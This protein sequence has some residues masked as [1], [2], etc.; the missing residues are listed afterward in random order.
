M[1]MPSI[2]IIKMYCK[3]LKSFILSNIKFNI[4]LLYQKDLKKCLKEFL[5]MVTSIVNY[6]LLQPTGRK[7]TILTTRVI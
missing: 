1:D 5:L 3:Y 2:E 7:L 4:N 6:V